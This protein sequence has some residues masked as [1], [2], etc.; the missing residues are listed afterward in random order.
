MSTTTTGLA[1]ASGVL[2]DEQTGEV[3]EGGADLVTS[4]D[5][6]YKAHNEYMLAQLQYAERL[7][8]LTQHDPRLQALSEKV[9][10]AEQVMAQIEETLAACRPPDPNRTYSIDTERVRVTWARGSRRWSQ[11]M[12]PETIAEQDPELARKL[13]I[14]QTVGD[15]P[16]PRITYRDNK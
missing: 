3:I 1:V 10:G 11:T 16:K 6:L 15:P 14:S 9:K 4:L 2:V 12:K 8:V 7:D 5:T 13:G